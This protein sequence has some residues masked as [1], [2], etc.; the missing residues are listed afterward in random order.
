MTPPMNAGSEPNRTLNQN[1]IRLDDKAAAECVEREQGRKLGD[2]SLRSVQAEPREA[3]VASGAV[4][5]ST[6]GETKAK[7]RR[8]QHAEQAV[9]DNDRAIRVDCRSPAADQQSARA[10]PPTSAPAAVANEPTRLNQANMRVRCRSGTVCAKCRLLD[11][12][13][14]PDLVAGRA[15]HADRRRRPRARRTGRRDEH[16][17]GQRASAARRRSARGGGRFG[18]R[19]SSARGEMAASPSQRQGQ[20]EADLRRRHAHGGQVEH[21]HD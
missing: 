2:D 8:H 12:Q 16:G 11:G 17:R 6:A 13:K 21:E 4:G 14:R 15:D 1:A 10:T 19:G 9:R 18:R 20:Q 7:S 5:T 3:I